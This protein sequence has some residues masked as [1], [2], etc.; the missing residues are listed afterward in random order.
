MS[1]LEERLEHDLNEIRDHI[2]KMGAEVE[3]ALEGAFRA[4]EKNNDKLAFKTILSDLPINRHMRQIDRL[5]HAFIAVHL[6]SAG[7]LRLISSVI[8]CNIILERV[9]DYAVTIAREA[10]QLGD[11]PEGYMSSELKKVSAEAMAVLSE[12]IT[13]FNSSNAERARHAITMSKQVEHEM[14]GIYAELLDCGDADGGCGRNTMI[15]LIIFSQLKRVADQAKN[16]AEEAIFIET[17][18]TKSP[19]IYRI[20]FMDESNSCLGP[21]AALIAD[22]AFHDLGQFST[23]G[24]KAANSLDSGMVT[25]MQGR[26]FNLADI[27]P[28]QVDTSRESL[29]DFHVIVG[30]N[31]KVMKAVG[32]I[33]FRTSALHW[34]KLE[35]PENDDAQA[36]ESL[37][38]NLALQIQELM[39]LLHGDEAR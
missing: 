36:W 20:L 25:F 17:G 2:A 21:M 31:Q 9:G 12:A 5:C 22:K 18:E 4:L 13:S 7:H 11:V 38:K 28:R 19:K 37:Y 39:T 3:Q 27:T 34:K 16:L 29:S 8:R 15:Y 30:L 23:A 35:Q 32:Q 33:P 1:H 26:G 6:P 24:M 14:D 10:V